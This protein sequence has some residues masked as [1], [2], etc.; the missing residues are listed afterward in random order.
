MKPRRSFKRV[1][2]AKRSGL[3]QEVK[4]Y[5]WQNWLQRIICNL[6]Q[7]GEGFCMPLS[8]MFSCWDRTGCK[9][10]SQYTSS[11][12]IFVITKLARAYTK[13]S[14]PNF[15]EFVRDN[16]NWR[17]ILWY[18]NVLASVARLLCKNLKRLGQTMVSN[19]TLLTKLVKHYCSMNGYTLNWFLGSFSYSY[20]R[21]KNWYERHC[22][23]RNCLFLP[24][25]S[26]AEKAFRATWGATNIFWGSSSH[27]NYTPN[28]VRAFTST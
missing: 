21:I 8:A 23:K 16:A 28:P 25:F 12:D 20:C 13:S 5:I 24:R 17:R 4:M 14:G 22:E 26:T 7:S 9:K 3:W 6:K 27:R 10:C 19:I 1:L 15:L 18:R 2:S 11:G